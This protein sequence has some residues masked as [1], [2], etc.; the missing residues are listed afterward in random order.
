MPLITCPDCKKPISDAT[1]TCIHCGHLIKT[2]T[3]ARPEPTTNLELTRTPT[4]LSARRPEGLHC[5]KCGSTEVQRLD[6]AWHGGTSSIDANTVGGLSGGGSGVGA[7]KTSGTQ[8][9]ALAENA[10]PP[11]RAKLF[12]P[13]FA[14]SAGAIG[15]FVG[16]LVGASLWSMLFYLS[17]AFGSAFTAYE[18]HQYNREEYLDLLR[19]WGQSFVCLQCGQ[20]LRRSAVLT[21]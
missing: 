7:A 19:E 2:A 10:A 11:E 18:R 5:S 8:R 3:Q 13:V 17:V 14:A 4:A 15:L 21:Q 9:P 6:V 16:P 1:P 20:K 12:R